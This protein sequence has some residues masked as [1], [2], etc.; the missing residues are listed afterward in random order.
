MARAAVRSQASNRRKRPRDSTAFASKNPTHQ[1]AP[2]TAN[3]LRT[4]MAAVN[5]GFTWP[6]VRKSLASEQRTT[7][8][9]N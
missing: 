7:A 9:R 5:R 3:R 2:N 1:T 4:K 8:A 6:G